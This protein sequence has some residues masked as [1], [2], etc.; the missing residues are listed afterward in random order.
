MLK[1]QGSPKTLLKLTRE[2]LKP[3]RDKL[4]APMGLKFD[5]PN[6]VELYLFGADYFVVE[7]FNDE[8]VDVTL[9][10]P[11]VLKVKKA[12]TLPEDATNVGLSQSGNSV[13]IRISPRTLVAVEYR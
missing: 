7:N 1:V 4:L 9:D 5:A 3:I 10:F 8:A 2:E 6:E 11:R 12:L 13:K